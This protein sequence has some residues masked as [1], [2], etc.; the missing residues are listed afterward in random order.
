MRL[1]GEH[2]W[3]A[4]QFPAQPVHQGDDAGLLA[5]RQGQ[6]EGAQADPAGGVLLADA[7]AQQLG[8]VLQQGL[9]GLAAVLEEE[10]AKILHLDLHQAQRLQV[11]AGVGDV[12][13]QPVDEPGPVGQAG[14]RVQGDRLLQLAGHPGVVGMGPGPGDQVAGGEGLGDE[15]GGAAV[16]R[17]H[18]RLLVV[19][20]TG[21]DDHRQ[22]LD[23]AVVG[24]PDLVQQAV[25]I[26]ARHVQVGED[27]LDGRVGLQLGPGV[28]AVV[29][30]DDVELVAEHLHRGLAHQSG[31][32]H[33]EDARPRVGLPAHGVSPAQVPAQSKPS[34]RL[35]PSDAGHASAGRGRPLRRAWPGNGARGAAARRRPP[36]GPGPPRP[37]PPRPRGGHRRPPPGCGPATACAWR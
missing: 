32:V 25:A 31:I 35:D 8:D 21:D 33:H 27:R 20:G 6:A 12:L 36:P 16:Q 9:G 18:P 34:Q 37:P 1:A 24:A 14:G 29:A 2:R 15:I 13:L 5:A 3:L 11:P 4:G 23:A 22:A 26:Q 7:P 28:Q 19:L 10:A 17:L 30:G